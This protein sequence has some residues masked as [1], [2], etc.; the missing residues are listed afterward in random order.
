MQIELKLSM[1]IWQGIMTLWAEKKGFMILCLDESVK[2]ELSFGK[3]PPPKPSSQPTKKSHQDK[4]IQTQKI[5]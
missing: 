3:N 2:R 5:S 1:R 4:P